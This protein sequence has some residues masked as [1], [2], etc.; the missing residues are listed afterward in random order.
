MEDEEERIAEVNQYFSDTEHYSIPDNPLVGLHAQE[1]PCGWYGGS[2]SLQCHV[3]VGAYNYFNLAAFQKHLSTIKW[4]YP[5][6]VQLFVKG[7]GDEKF[8]LIQGVMEFD[9]RF[10]ERD[11]LL[12]DAEYFIEE[13][14]E[15]SDR[16]DA[17]K[18]LQEYK[19]FKA[20]EE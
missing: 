4:V 5:E 14:H 6:D 18:W 7:E 8:K 20:G 1:L 16:E 15:C 12:C 9:S 17:L 19:T 10:V 13:F 11:R 2:K 3:Y